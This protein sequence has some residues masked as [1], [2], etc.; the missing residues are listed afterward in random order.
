MIEWPF[1]FEAIDEEEESVSLYEG[2]KKKILQE[3]LHPIYE[4][5]FEP[6]VNSFLYEIL[7]SQAALVKDIIKIFDIIPF[8]GTLEPL[9]SQVRMCKII[10]FMKCLHNI[11]NVKISFN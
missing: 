8:Y 1:N 5:F 2:N 9:E 11:L 4:P 7:P 10:L 3:K 6:E